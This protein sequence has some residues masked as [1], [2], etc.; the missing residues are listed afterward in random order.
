MNERFVSNAPAEVVNLER[1]KKEDTETKIAVLK[2]TL[3][4]LRK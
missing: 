1:K 3:D 2:A 4:N